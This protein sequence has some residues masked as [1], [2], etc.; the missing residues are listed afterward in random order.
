MAPAPPAIPI[1]LLLLGGI[2][3]RDSEPNKTLVITCAAKFSGP[4]DICTMLQKTPDWSR[5]SGRA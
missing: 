2:A 4:H 5:F 3:N 1:V